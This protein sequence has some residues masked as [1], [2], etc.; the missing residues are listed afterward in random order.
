MIMKNKLMNNIIKNVLIT[1]VTLSLLS[2]FQ[3]TSADDIYKG[4]RGPTNWQLDSRM[5]YFENEQGIKTT[6]GNLIL[7]YWNGKKFGLWGFCNLP[8]KNIN[9]LDKSFK[10]FGDV[11]LG[12]GPRGTFD[13]FHWLSYASFIFPRGG[14]KSKQSLSNNRLD[15]KIGILGTYITSNKKYELDCIIEHNFTGKNNSE[16]NFPNET[17]IGMLGGKEITKKLKFATGLTSLI[18]DNSDYTLNWRA[19]FRYSISPKLH[20]ELVGDKGIKGNNV[21][22]STGIGFYARYNF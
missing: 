21:P 9:T 17:Y 10:G 4:V 18:K 19:V 12:I 5:S 8:Y 22:K 7:K 2:I 3:K 13:N 20:F 1:N 16:V 11:S 15:T 14:D 6:T